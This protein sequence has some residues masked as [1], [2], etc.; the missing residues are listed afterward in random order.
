[1]GHRPIVSCKGILM[2]TI[3]LTV[4]KDSDLNSLSLY[5]IHHGRVLWA[6]TLFDPYTRS[7]MVGKGSGYRNVFHV[8]CLLIFDY[9]IVH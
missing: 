7:L 9:W 2:K 8:A 4:K 5:M 1:M 6:V 3:C